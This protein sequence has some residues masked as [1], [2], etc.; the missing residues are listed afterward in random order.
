MCVCVRVRVCLLECVRVCVCACV[1][2]CVRACARV[3][4]CVCVCVCVLRLVHICRGLAG[5]GAHHGV[6]SGQ[7]WDNVDAA[8][9]SPK[10]GVAR[11]LLSH[12]ACQALK[13]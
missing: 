1:R 6:P 4:V 2:A 10:V 13:V 12:T 3:R 11:I 5:N 8:Q 9:G 7:G